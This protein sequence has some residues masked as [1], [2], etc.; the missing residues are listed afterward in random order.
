M[1]DR[2]TLRQQLELID[3]QIEAAEAELDV[4]RMTRRQLEAEAELRKLFA[5]TVG[6]VGEG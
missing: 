6:F 5:N 1:Q 4:L 3:R 2:D